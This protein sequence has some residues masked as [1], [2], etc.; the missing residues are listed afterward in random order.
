MSPRSKKE[1]IETIYLRY[2]NAS[3]NEK[4]LILD[5]FCATLGYHRKHAIR[6][7]R[8]FKR[9]R[10]TKT[11][12]PGQAPLYSHPSIHP[13]TPQEN[14]AGRQPALLQTPKNH[15]LALWQSWSSWVSIH[16]HKASISA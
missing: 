15:P 11:Q 10:E 7:L 6:V 1:Y 14:L 9:F 16:Y 2:R 3:R 5:E 8:K 4:V 12:R 13:Q